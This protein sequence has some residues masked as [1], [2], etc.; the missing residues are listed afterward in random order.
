MTTLSENLR[1]LLKLHPRTEAERALP[2]GGWP[3]W[4]ER[5]C[6]AGLITSKE[7]SAWQSLPRTTL[8]R[9]EEDVWLESAS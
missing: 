6:T 7:A 8:E 4:L 2:S 1:A 5:A 3:H 9:V